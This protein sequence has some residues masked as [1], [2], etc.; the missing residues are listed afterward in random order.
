[1]KF[2]DLF[3]SPESLR[4]GGIGIKR[5]FIQLGEN[6]HIGDDT[7]ISLA[8]G[9]KPDISLSTL[10]PPLVPLDEPFIN[11]SRYAEAG[12]YS[13]DRLPLYFAKTDGQWIRKHGLLLARH[14][15]SAFDP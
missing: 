11:D 5:H 7:N 9:T 10:S 1:M 15:E 8:S 6:I 14:S 3:T 13:L 2:D 12:V 4:I